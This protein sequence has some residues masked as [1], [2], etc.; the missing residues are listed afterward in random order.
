MR[1]TGLRADGTVHKFIVFADCG[2]AFLLSGE[3]QTGST[4]STETSLAQTNSSGSS[5]SRGYATVV[6]IPVVL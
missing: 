2:A 1:Q 4:F 5:G 3:Q 6:T